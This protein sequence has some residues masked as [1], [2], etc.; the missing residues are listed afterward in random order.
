[1][2]SAIKSATTTEMHISAIEYRLFLLILT[3][4]PETP[5]WW[6][7]SYE[8]ALPVQLAL[9]AIE[10]RADIAPAH[11]FPGGEF[12]LEVLLQR[13]HQRHMI[14]GIPARDLGRGQLVGQD[15]LR[16]IQ[17]FP[18]NH[19]SLAHDLIAAHHLDVLA[20]R[21]IESR[22]E[23]HPGAGSRRAPG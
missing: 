21:E 18:E 19:L 5:G 10:H 14:E 12:H 3:G 23:G 16:T 4:N 7:Q 15:E 11:H 17:D 8:P 20:S 22:L 13:H 2:P 6:K 1:M 9:Q